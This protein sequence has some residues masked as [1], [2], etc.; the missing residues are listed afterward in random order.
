[1]VVRKQKL[2]S[3]SEKD[4]DILEDEPEKF[5]ENVKIIGERAFAGCNLKS[6]KIPEQ[7]EQICDSAFE[8]CKKLTDVIIF[9]TTKQIG[10]NVFRGC[11][12]LEGINIF[13]KVEKNEEIKFVDDGLGNHGDLW[14]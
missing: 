10:R 2:I 1:M 3:V 11:D 13:Q 8:G 14:L 4:L 9:E 7:I 12:K 5:W 6:I